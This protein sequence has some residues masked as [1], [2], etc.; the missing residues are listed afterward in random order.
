MLLNSKLLSSIFRLLDSAR[1]TSCFLCSA[2]N[3]RN[4]NSQYRRSLH[5][6]PVSSSEGLRGAD[7]SQVRQSARRML[8]TRVSAEQLRTSANRRA[9]SP[10]RAGRFWFPAPR[11]S[12]LACLRGFSSD[13]LFCGSACRGCR[14]PHREADPDQHDEVDHQG[15]NADIE[16][17]DLRGQ[18]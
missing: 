6:D 17:L 4:E 14:N 2:L 11:T 13:G 7:H 15:H 10:T 8:R 9:K 16:I 5:R 12:V 18:P 1:M 3:D